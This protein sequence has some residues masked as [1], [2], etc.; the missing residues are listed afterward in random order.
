[1]WSDDKSRFTQ[2][3]NKRCAELKGDSMLAGSLSVTEIFDELTRREFLAGMVAAG[4]LG[5]CGLSSDNKKSSRSTRRVTHAFGEVE[6]PVDASRVVALNVTAADPVLTLKVP[7]VGVP[8]VLPPALEPLAQG[9][10]RLGEAEISLEQVASLRPDLLLTAA[11]QGEIFEGF[12]IETLERIAPTVA[13]EFQSD[14]RWREYYRY[15]ADVLGR[16][17][18]AEKVLGDL[19]DRIATLAARLPE[20]GSTTVS[21]IRVYDDS[22]LQNYRTD[23]S[24]AGS[25]LNPLGFAVPEALA[26]IDEVSLEN[27][28]VIDADALY[29]FHEQAGPAVEQLQAQPIYQQLNA[30]KAGKAFVVDN[31]WFGFGA[32]AA[33]AVLD[34]IESTLG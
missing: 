22:S 21:V 19:D 14:Y 31:H 32:L 8:G 12:P 17:D 34:D 4:L 5:A 13:Y 27:L 23:Q 28:A 29:I 24:F 1:V 18:D 25:I 2:V 20:T 26:G 30:V 9:I 10:E 7:A 3:A 33:G 11:Y 6:V 15:F 16:T